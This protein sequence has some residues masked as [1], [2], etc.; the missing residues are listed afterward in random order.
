MAARAVEQP[1]E[2]TLDAT[3]L[4]ARAA[5][6][7]GLVILVLILPA[8]VSDPWA[9]RIALMAIFGIIGLSFNVITG[10]A[11]QISLGHQA[12]VGIGAFSAAYAVGPHVGAGFIVGFVAAG[13]T[14]A[15]LA[16]ALGL[17]SLRVKGLY[18]ALVTLAFGLMTYTTIFQWR[19]FTGAGAST[20]DPRPAGFGSN[21]SYAYLCIAFLA[22]FL[23]VD[24]RMSKSKPGRAVVA[25]RNNEIA[26]SSLGINPRAYKLLAFAVGGFLAGVAGALLG[27]Y[28]TTVSPNTFNFPDPALVWLTMAV[29]GGLGSRAGI[30]MG[31]AFFAILSPTAQLLSVNLINVPGWLAWTGVK[32]VT[33][34]TTLGPLIGATL[35]LLTVTLYPGGLGQQLLPIRRWMAGGPFR[36][37]RRPG[38]VEEEIVPPLA[39]ALEVPTSTSLGAPEPSEGAEEAFADI[40][41]PPRQPEPEPEPAAPVEPAAAVEPEPRPEPVVEPVSVSEP[42]PEPETQEIAVNTSPDESPDGGEP[43]EEEEEEPAPRKSS[44]FGF[45]RR[46]DRERTP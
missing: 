28:N 31:A 14:G 39:A 9:G 43:E 23:F 10:Y 27:S 2:H 36:T 25:V 19:T 11:G 3:G 20:P 44:L 30:V 8:V 7:I 26:A 6:A 24:W 35:L 22:L 13:L 37:P 32:Q 46:K 29:V 33:L 15:F 45:R 18:F 17:V 40:D 16:F 21:T 1:R 41:E 34:A 4:I 38:Y 42:E 5:A 12:F